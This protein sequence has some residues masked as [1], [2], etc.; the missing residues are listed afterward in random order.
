[1][2]NLETMIESPQRHDRLS[3]FLRAF[4]LRGRAV[5]PGRSAE[6]AQLVALGPLSAPEMLIFDPTDARPGAAEAIAL[7]VEIGFEGSRNPL[8]GAVTGPVRLTL[9]DHPTLAALTAALIEEAL[10]RRCG[11]DA[12]SARL[13]EVITLH[14]LRHAIASGSTRPGL[15]AGLA[16]ESL[17]RALV[18]MHDA[19]A[20]GWTADA[21]AATAGMSRSAF[22]AAFRATV[23]A[24]PLAYLTRWRLTLARR[25]IARGRT[26]KVAARRVGF[27]SPEA[28]S[29]AHRR[30]FGMPPLQ[31]AAER[32]PASIGPRVAVA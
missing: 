8:L 15:L 16:H 9:A 11:A 14:M 10:A 13:A 29:R 1:M 26:V 27:G 6:P 4:A 21:L 28:L 24:P 25:E 12:A 31:A 7:S 5:A 17:H 19:P 22:M 30:I 3:A 23:G 2:E 20:H 18:A 32:T